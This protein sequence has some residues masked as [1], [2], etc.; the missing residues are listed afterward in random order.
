MLGYERCERLLGNADVRWFLEEALSKPRLDRERELKELGTAKEAREIAAHVHA[1]LE[2][3]EQFLTRR[4]DIYYR[5]LP[6]AKK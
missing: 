4:R 1:A 2:Q 5:D 3:A 6:Q